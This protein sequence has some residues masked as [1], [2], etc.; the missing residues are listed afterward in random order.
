MARLKI[1]GWFYPRCN[2]FDSSGIIQGW[3]G[4]NLSK[5]RTASSSL[6]CWFLYPY[7]WHNQSQFSIPQLWPAEPGGVSD[8]FA[9]AGAALLQHN[10][11]WGARWVF[12]A[13]LL[14][15]CLWGFTRADDPHVP[16]ATGW[17]MAEQVLPLLPL[18][19]SWLMLSPSVA[20]SG[21]A[22][23]W[24]RALLF[25]V[26]VLVVSL[27]VLLHQRCPALCGC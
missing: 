13:E 23:L 22:G 14:G 9:A 2:A 15:I 17:L 6:T 24:A 26:G 3:N 12:P 5:Q 20:L 27:C 21:A 25:L 10:I 16:T 18:A 11:S 4:S 19:C 8:R 1:M 7:L